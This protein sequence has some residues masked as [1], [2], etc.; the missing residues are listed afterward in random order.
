MYS[1]KVLVIGDNAFA[2]SV[3]EKLSYDNNEQKLEIISISKQEIF[4]NLCEN[5]YLP[6]YDIEKIID[7]VSAR[8]ISLS[9]ACSEKLIAS[10]IV[11]AFQEQG[12]NIFGPT[13]ISTEICFSHHAAKE[14]MHQNLIPSEP[15]VSFDSKEV[16]LAY[17]AHLNFPVIIR[18]DFLFETNY[19]KKVFIADDINNATAFI[20]EYFSQPFL[21]TYKKRLIIEAY[22]EGE[23]FCTSILYDGSTALSLVPIKMHREYNEYSLTFNEKSANSLSDGS[24]DQLQLEINEKIIKPFLNALAQN[25][26]DEESTENGIPLR[27]FSGFISFITKLNLEGE[28]ILDRFEVLAPDLSAELSLDLIEENL[29]DLLFSCT[30]GKLNFYHDGLRYVNLCGV[31]VDLN[32]S[33][34]ASSYLNEESFLQIE[35][36]ASDANYRIKVQILSSELKDSVRLFIYAP[37]E[38]EAKNFAMTVATELNLFD[39]SE[40]LL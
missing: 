31:A 15:Y 6:E 16:C 7:I 14:F 34:A 39:E 23:E 12:L 2:R 11:E 10:G 32:Y 18:P 28:I 4:S 33:K 21:S 38:V 22:S 17:L 3:I 8:R 19:E 20:E 13:S 35:R 1:I 37:T 9:I 24:T 5:I 29:F 36:T 30:Q 40:S 27:S 26:E 25:N